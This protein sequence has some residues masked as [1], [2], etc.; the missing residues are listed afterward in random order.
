MLSVIFGDCHFWWVSHLNPLCWMSLGGVSLCWLSLCWLSWHHNVNNLLQVF[1]VWP[2][3]AVRSRD[4]I[5]RLD[6]ALPANIW[7]AS[8]GRLVEQKLILS[9][10][11]RCCQIHNCHRYDFGHTLLRFLSRTKMFNK[12]TSGKNTLAYFGLI[13]VTKIF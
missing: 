8:R 6:L 3:F 13:A 11:F 2:T 10:S 1:E 4:S 12:L 9:S 7:L 5:V